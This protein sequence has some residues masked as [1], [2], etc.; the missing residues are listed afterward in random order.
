MVIEL[1]SAN[2]SKVIRDYRE[3]HVHGVVFEPTCVDRWL[4][5]ESRRTVDW[6]ARPDLL[7]EA[8]DRHTVKTCCDA[9]IRAL[10]CVG[11]IAPTFLSLFCLALLGAR[12]LLPLPPSKGIPF[13]TLQ[14]FSETLTP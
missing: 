14:L 2:C 10:H 4:I 1:N 12:Q 8:S 9:V 13:I 7:W 5:S 3:P 11:H 6:M